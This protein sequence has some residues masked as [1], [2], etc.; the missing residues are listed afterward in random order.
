MYLKIFVKMFFFL[1]KDFVFYSI[2]RINYMYLEELCDLEN[3]ILV[4]IV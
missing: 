2:Y 1:E 3:V 4:S